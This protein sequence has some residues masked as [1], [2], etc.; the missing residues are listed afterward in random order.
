MC[1]GIKQAAEA[2]LAKQLK[3]RGPQDCDE[4][5]SPNQNGSG[6]MAVYRPGS[7]AGAWVV[8]AEAGRGE[9]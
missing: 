2:L 1:V 9:C 8:A 5:A 4:A 7:L 6:R 3:S